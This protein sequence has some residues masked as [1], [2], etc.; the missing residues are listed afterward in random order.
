MESVLEYCPAMHFIMLQGTE[1]KLGMGVGGRTRVL[2]AY[3]QSDPSKIK[4]H[5]EVKLP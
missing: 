4:G 2:R 1:L 3:F 5:P